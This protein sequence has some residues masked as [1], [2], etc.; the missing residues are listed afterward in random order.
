MTDLSPDKIEL[1]RGLIA[2]SPDDV[3]RGLERAVCREGASGSLAAIGAMIE[4]EVSERA[5]RAHVLAPVNGLF[6]A[7]VAPDRNAF[8]RAAAGL[9]WKAL[10][11]DRPDLVRQAVDASY[12]IDPAEPPPAIFDLLCGQAADQLKACDK[13][14]YAAVRAVLEADRAG[15]TQ[16]LILAL[17]MAP[18][19]RPPLLRLPEWLQ[20][21]SDD[22]RASARIAYKDAGAAGDGGGPLMFEMLAAH[23]KHPSQILRVISAVM[24]HPGERYLADSELAIFGVRALDDI[25]IQVRRARELRPGTGDAVA[26]QAAAAVIEAVEIITELDQSVQLVRDGPWGQRLVKQK[27]ALAALVE[28]RMQ[29][30]EEAVSLCLPMKKLRYSGRLVS[31]VPNLDEPPSDGA[32][33]LAMGLLTFSEGV[34]SCA[35]E[36]GFAG[37]RSKVHDIVGQ[38][39]DRYVDD[40][41]EQMRLGDEID[42]DRARDYL[43]VAARL[44]TLVRDRQAGGVVRRRAAAA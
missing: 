3:V 40:L 8:P 2:A 43:D 6:R 24:D 20:R 26:E 27:Q 18:I 22:R 13:P 12:Y 32:V 30:I 37:A 15:S 38:R 28:Q 39:I 4:Q 25:D 36:G 1:L 34:R 35:N 44:M 7:R 31:N 41:L 23:L 11:A 10:K 17:E 21:M 9:L 33:R 14:E 29:E 19:V 16:T 42:T 5:A